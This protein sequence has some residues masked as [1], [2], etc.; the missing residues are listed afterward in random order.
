MK[1]QIIF[2]SGA[3]LTVDMDKFSATRGAMG[4][5]TQLSITAPD[6]YKYALAYVDVT[7]IVAIAEIR[8]DSDK[9]VKEEST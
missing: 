8:E 4:D 2:K 7:E 1:V 3:K 5:L 6:D 9:V